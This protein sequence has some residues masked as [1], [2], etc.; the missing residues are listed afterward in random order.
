V[1]SGS[2]KSA[3]WIIGL[4][5]VGVIIYILLNRGWGNVLGGITG[6]IKTGDGSEGDHEQDSSG[7]G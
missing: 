3:L 6:K 2:A 5:V 7:E 4:V 1:G